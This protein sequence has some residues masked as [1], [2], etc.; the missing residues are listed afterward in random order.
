MVRAVTKWRARAGRPAEV[1]I[2]GYFDKAGYTRR[3]ERAVTERVSSAITAPA[4]CRS[5]VSCH[6]RSPMRNDA[7]APRTV[8]ARHVA[9]S[10]RTEHFAP[11]ARFSRR[12]AHSARLLKEGGITASRGPMRLA[13][14]ERAFLHG[15]GLGLAAAAG[16]G[17]RAW[18][19]YAALFS[20]SPPVPSSH[21][22]TVHRRRPSTCFSDDDVEWAMA[23]RFPLFRADRDLVGGAGADGVFRWTWTV[24]PDRLHHQGLGSI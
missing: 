2:E 7:L 9:F 23:N 18:T 11:V 20:R 1:V 13:G 10:L 6:E 16:A 21:H 3:F 4:P 14:R 24:G 19:R 12:A 5:G 17:P 15:A 22:L 8:F